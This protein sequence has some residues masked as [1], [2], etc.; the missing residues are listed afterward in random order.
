MKKIAV[1]LIM[2]A[3]PCAAQTTVPG[4]PIVP[5]GYCQIGSSAL[6]SAAKL[7]ANCTI[8]VGAT[9]AYL[10][11]E[12]ADVRYRDD[13]AAPTTAV[14]S[15][16]L[17]GNPGIFYNGPLGALQF[18]GASGSPVLDVAFYRQ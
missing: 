9:M 11:A 10:Q 3:A 13:G 5:L 2:L 18:I 12:S 17:G 14:G 7:S 16:I 8:P 15:L 6:G 1:V 4:Q